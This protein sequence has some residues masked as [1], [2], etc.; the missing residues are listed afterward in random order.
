MQSNHY[1]NTT[2]HTPQ[3]K[4]SRST[5][6]ITPQHCDSTMYTRNN[7][8]SKFFN[9]ITKQKNTTCNIAHALYTLYIQTRNVPKMTKTIHLCKAVQKMHVRF[10][11]SFSPK[12]IYRQQNIKY[13][14]ILKNYIKLAKINKLSK[15][16]LPSKIDIQFKI[17]YLILQ[18][19]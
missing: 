2:L 4:Y 5:S 15:T 9:N 3:D 16:F 8:K 6:I 7:K 1:K 18:L 19:T 13:N 14:M 12:N 10:R 11:K 17:N